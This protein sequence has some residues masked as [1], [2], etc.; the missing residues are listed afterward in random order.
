M[1][2]NTSFKIAVG[3]IL[4]VCLLLG[5]VYY[6]YHQTT[7]LTQASG[8]EQRLTERR[9]VTHQLLSQLFETETIGQ[10][11]HFGEWDIYQKYAE[12]LSRVRQTIQVLD[13]M[14]TDSLPHA[15][16]DTLSTLLTNKQENM[17]RLVL[18]LA[19]NKSNQIYQKQISLLLKNRDTVV[20][21]TSITRQ[22][23]QKDKSYTIKKEPKKGFFR[24]LAAAFHQ[25][26]TDTTGVKQSVQILSTDTIQQEFNA[27]DTLAHILDS[28]ESDIKIYNHKRQQRINAQAEKL[29]YTGI[30][31]NS[32]VTQ[33]LESIEY[34]EQ[35]SLEEE[36]QKAY[37]VR[38]QAALTTGIIAMAAILLA[39]V[40]FVI[41]WRDIMR[42]NHYRKELEKAKKKAEDLLV[43]H[44]KLMLTVTHDIKAPVGSI[45]G[46]TEL[47]TPYIK[48]QCEKNYLD[49]I[50][51]SSEH[52]LSLVGSL[53]DYHKLEAHKMDVQP[54]S[55]N[56]SKLLH[57][58]T[59]CFLPQAGKKHLT[60]RC[61][62]SPETDRTYQGDAF[63]IRQI[64]DNLVSNALKFTQKGEILIKAKIHGRLLC[65]TV[66]DTGCGMSVDEQKL[67]FKEFTRLSSAQGEE[68]VGLGLSIT[69]KLVPLL[70]GEI[71]LDSSPGQGSS[72][73]LALPLQPADLPHSDTAQAAEIPTD[74]CRPQHILLI[75]DDRIQ[76]QLTQT[77]LQQ[78]P[79][80]QTEW[81][82]VACRQPEEVFQQVK[83][84]RFDVLLTDIQMP[85]MNG[86]DQVDALQRL[87]GNINAALPVV[88]ITARSDMNETFFRQHGFSTCLYKPFNRND[89]VRA[90]KTAVNLFIPTS[91]AED[92][93][94]SP[95]PPSAGMDFAALTAFAS[96]DPD[97]AREI[98]R[99]FR[100]ET[101]Q[102]EKDFKRACEQKNKGEVC[103][104]AHKL[105][106]TF[107][108]IGA[109][110]IGALQTRDRR[111][112]ETEWQEAD[113]QPAGAIADSF[114]LVLEAL[115]KQES[116]KNT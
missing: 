115:R 91:P 4:L 44:E 105:L 2:Q 17:R 6:I 40:F 86:F 24:R 108:L 28:I 81:E 111:R 8:N 45:L 107:T 1:K 12:S 37:G 62:T 101:L 100:E 69:L 35:Q 31:L 103:R 14:F 56:P 80:G 76:L 29:W 71:Q 16:L 106:P 41:V 84:R 110:C 113:E 39:F 7:S 46:Y 95:C 53:L 97:A 67:V 22:V 20:Q 11:I 59:Q 83:Q 63:R 68:G 60:L 87:E 75:D 102:N 19:N 33:L 26:K 74:L 61:E 3:Y 98:L 65:L 72:F 9:K 58:I 42:S 112:E 70:K 64:V 36:S 92:A 55:F 96:D 78:I 30:E 25:P 57:T 10:A 32:R 5:S 34:E 77:M 66:K 52:L 21:K 43:S 23:I 51:S 54:V 15:R 13:T 85:A 48:E 99:T 114:N 93:P 88:A 27:S 38:K 109:P 89:L 116:N 90:L 104:I 18:A 82:I 49:N 73:F 50:R 94:E 47:L 79:H